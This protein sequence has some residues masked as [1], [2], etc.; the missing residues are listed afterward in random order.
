[1]EVFKSDNQRPIEPL[2]RPLEG[3]QSAT[4]QNRHPTRGNFVLVR[5]SAHVLGTGLF[6]TESNLARTFDGGTD[7]DAAQA[8]EQYGKTTCDAS[9]HDAGSGATSS[10]LNL[11]RSRLRT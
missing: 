8:L 6:V 4:F 11:P 1:M 2:Q 3:P 9:K 7:D 5:P 10:A